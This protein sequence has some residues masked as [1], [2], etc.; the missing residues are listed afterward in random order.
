[1]ARRFLALAM[2]VAAQNAVGLL[3]MWAGI[4]LGSWFAAD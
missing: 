2:D 4:A 3:A 1:M